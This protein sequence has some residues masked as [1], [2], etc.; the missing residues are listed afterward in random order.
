M[1]QCSQ[2]IRLGGILDPDS[3]IVKCRREP[4]SVHVLY[5]LGN[6]T[7]RHPQ[8]AMTST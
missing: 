3:R 8:P 1:R 5:M 6:T 7:M 2:Q 4:V